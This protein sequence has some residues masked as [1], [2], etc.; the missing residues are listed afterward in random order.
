MNRY[1]NAQFLDISEEEMIEAM[2][3]INAKVEEMMKENEEINRKAK[4]KEM[5]REKRL[6]ELRSKL[7]KLEKSMK[8]LY[9][10]VCGE[11]S[12]SYK[13]LC[14]DE[15]YYYE[16]YRSGE[17]VFISCGNCGVSS[18][19]FRNG[20]GIE[21]EI[22]MMEELKKWWEEFINKVKF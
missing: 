20:C 13:C 3:R 14:L 10:P 1:W 16:G 21:N 15:E 19:H 7:D 22:K 4:L 2:E 8:N 11:F 12:S 18:K 6:Q 5:E 9:C 17:I